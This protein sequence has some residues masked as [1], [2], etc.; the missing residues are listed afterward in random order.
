[1]LKALS[2]RTGILI[3]LAFMTLL[4]LLVSG[5]G[6]IA[7]N[8]SYQSM[9]VINRIQGIELGNLAS[10]NTNMQRVRV[11][12]SFAI[13]ALETGQWDDAAAAAGRSAQYAN[14]AKEDL[15]RFFAATRGTG[16][17]EQ[18]AD[19]IAQAYQNYYEH[20]ITPML[21][22]LKNRDI[23][24]YYL[25][26]VTQLRQ[27]GT[28]F[29]KANKDYFDYAQQAGVEQLGYAALE[30][31][32]M[33]LLIGACCLLVV[34]LVIF[35]WVILRHIL[36]KPL[37]TAIQHLE[38]VAAGDLTQTL[39]PCGPN[40]LG[41]LN[42]AL[43]AMQQSLATSVIR[44]REASEQIDVGSRELAQGNEDLSRRTEESAA[45]LQQTAASMEQLSSTVRNNAENA[46]QGHDLTEDVANTAQQGSRVVQEVTEK[47]Q[48][49]STSAAS[50]SNILSVIDGIAFQ[51]NILALNAAVEA[52]RAGEQGRGFAVVANEVRTLAQRSAQA[53]KEIHALIAD[54]NLRVAEGSQL[55]TRAR[56]T[57]S[58]I[59][60]QII[61][62]NVLMKEISQASQ[63]QSHGIDQI[64]IAV[65][66]MEDVAQH[67]A[68]LVEQASMATRSLAEQSRELIVA[69]DAFRVKRERQLTAPE[70]AIDKLAIGDGKSNPVIPA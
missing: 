62:V 35:S 15:Q 5:M 32:R 45:S 46:R 9:N 54:S 22:A 66:Q 68:S 63:E 25:Y 55:T 4:L 1:M 20:G 7:I 67:N 16:K 12:A 56:E 11:A 3:L 30:R 2:I 29:D 31:S 48:E 47:M 52:A 39:P 70:L 17:G 65:N 21:D 64:N 18:L 24:R 69:M 26:Q 40:E 27:L 57:M 38:F 60:E 61:N 41:R 23:E 13:R 28:I 36:L 53:S 19:V 8:K 44:V 49:I 10:S 50:I 14:A 42:A 58:A 33:L 51:T 37:N 34:T 6:I 43:Q 59:S